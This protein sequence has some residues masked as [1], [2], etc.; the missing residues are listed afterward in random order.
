[1]KKKL[2]LKKFHE[3]TVE[4]GLRE[5]RN[6]FKISQNKNRGEKRNKEIKDLRK[7]RENEVIL[8]NE[9]RKISEIRIRNHNK[10]ERLK[11]EKNMLAV[12]R[13]RLGS[14]K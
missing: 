4:K 11:L 13:A 12:L 2:R 14:F 7:N 1:M 3:K 8:E 5:K 9:I 6:I 10:K